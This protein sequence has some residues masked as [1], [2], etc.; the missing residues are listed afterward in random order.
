MSKTEKP[1]FRLRLTQ[2]QRRAVA[3]LMPH[4]KSDLL[5]D[6]TNQRTLRLTL[7]EMKGIAV[8]CAQAVPKAPTGM[9]RNSLRGVVI[10]AAQA[11]DRFEK[12]SI[13]RIRAS[14]RLYQFKITLKDFKPPIWRRIQVKDCTLDKLHEH[15]QTSM[16]WTN[17]HLHH[18]KIDDQL[19]GD[20][21]LLEE[22]FKEMGYEDSTNTKLSDIVPKSGKRCRF[23]YEYDFG[24]GWEHEILFEGCV[25]AEKG[26]RYPI[27]VEGERACPPEDV[28]GTYGYQ[29]YLVAIADPE[30]ERHDE[31]LEWSGPFDPEAFDA[32]AASRE[33]R[34]GLPNWREEEW[35]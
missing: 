30:H 20:P 21:M 10:A 32:K 34:K 12:G 11:L 18:F 26:A 4:L 33:M 15:I 13:A 29:E 28:G 1:T 16:G 2:A 5:L 22:N 35:I 9:E 25:R 3:G 17:S 27:C 7:E 8:K 19:H 24:D 31:L 14:G 23:E 6:Q